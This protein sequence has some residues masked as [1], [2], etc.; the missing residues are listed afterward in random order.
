MGAV[1]F[2]VRTR[3]NQL[4]CVRPE[5]SQVPVVLFPLLDVPCVI[6]IGFLTI[7]KLIAS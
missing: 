3:G 4:D 7:A 1:I 2:V 6:R 5:D